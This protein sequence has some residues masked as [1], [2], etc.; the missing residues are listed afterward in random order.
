MNM[1]SAL[2]L[3]LAL[4]AIPGIGSAGVYQEQVEN[5]LTIVKFAGLAGGWAETHAGATGTL[6]DGGTTAFTLSLKRGITYKIFSVCDQDCTDIDLA[7]FDER[8]NRI[9]TDT[10]SD[11]YP[12]VEVTPRWTGPFTLRVAMEACGRNPCDFGV[13]VLGK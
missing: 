1:L 4:A 2:A 12:Y 10:R 7:L 5:K 6:R 3:A 13:V 9:S 8:D 11:A